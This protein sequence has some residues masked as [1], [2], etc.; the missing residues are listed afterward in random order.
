MVI[1]IC[2]INKSRV[3]LGR[4]YQVFFN[5]FTALRLH[6]AIEIKHLRGF[7]GIMQTIILQYFVSDSINKKNVVAAAATFCFWRKG[8][9]YVLSEHFTFALAYFSCILLQIT[10]NLQYAPSCCAEV[11]CAISGVK[12][13]SYRFGA[14]F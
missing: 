3:P 10:E 4:I 1:R 5:H 11:P 7:F 2:P 13:P 9:D 12:Q 14:F 8:G 6:S